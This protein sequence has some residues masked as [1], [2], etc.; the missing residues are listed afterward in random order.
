M[1]RPVDPAPPCGTYNAYMRHHRNG[2]EIDDACMKA[3]ADEGRK[4]NATAATVLA[5]RKEEFID[6]EPEVDLKAL[7]DLD[8]ALENLRIVRAS[9]KAAPPNAIANLSKRRQELTAYIVQ[10]RDA[11]SEGRTDPVDDI[12]ARRAARSAVS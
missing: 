1:A 4:K 3:N 7:K 10:L 12:A 8:D 11:L 2:E 6:R 9:M 5:E